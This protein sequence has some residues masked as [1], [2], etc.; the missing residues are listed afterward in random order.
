MKPIVTLAFA[1]GLLVTSAA[2]AQTST[3]PTSV[4]PS[5]DGISAVSGMSWIRH[6]N[7]RFEE[8]AMGKTGHLGPAPEQ[9]DST[10]NTQL[11]LISNSAARL[12][13]ADLYRLN[14]RGCHG[15]AGQGVPPE[16]NSVISPVRATSALLVLQ[17]MKSTGMEMSRSAA[18]QMSQE[19]S[20]ALMKRFHE[21]GENMP[22][23]AYLNE[24]EISAI[25]GYLKQLAG[26]PASDAKQIVIESPTRIG[27]LVVKSTCHI[28]HDATGANPTPQEMFVGAIPP[29]EALPHRVDEARFIRK[30]TEGSVIVMGADPIP[31]R[32]RMPVFYYLSKQEAAD[33]YLYLHQYPP[34]HSKKADFYLVSS[35]NHSAS[36]G[37]ASGVNGSTTPPATEPPQNDDQNSVLAAF[38]LIGLYGF[39]TLMIAGG[40]VFTIREFKRL[41]QN[42]HV[43]E[44]QIARLEPSE[45]PSL[46]GARSV[47]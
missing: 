17:R 34:L 46:V 44:N 20:V 32:G 29:I 43:K 12:R 30:V 25:I 27:E 39:V 11:F 13:G 10:D 35:Q 38:V 15:D 40:V 24:A 37:G 5:G 3:D 19:A 4:R 28:C 16:I 6:L 22:S 23:F 7:R 18:T 33:A 21:G 14:C 1:A 8:T 9:A 36:G 47:H 2:R 41:S 45:I 42:P 26:V 31:Y